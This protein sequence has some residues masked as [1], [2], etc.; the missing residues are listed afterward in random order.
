MSEKIMIE[1]TI[2]ALEGQRSLLGNGV[3]DVTTAVLREKLATHI[4]ATSQPTQRKL[5]TILFATI[6]GLNQTGPNSNENLN[7]VLMSA[8]WEQLT[9]TITQQGGTITAQTSTQL[10][11]VFG[12]PTSREDD[13]ERAVSTAL[14]LKETFQNFLL[15]LQGYARSSH[16]ELEQLHLMIGLNTG[17]VF[18]GEV[19][20]RGEYTVLGDAVNVASRL[21]QLAP[22]DTVLISH[23]THALLRDEF[24]VE[25]LGPIAVRGKQEPVRVYEVR[26]VRKRPLTFNFGVSGVV[27]RLVG[28]EE[29]FE[30]L[31]ESLTKTLQTRTGE[32][33]MVVGQAGLGKSRLVYEF[34][35]WA[36]G[37]P[38]KISIIN[39]RT[40]QQIS[41]SASP[42]A[43][44]RDI[45][46]T[47]ANLQ[48]NDS[49]TLAVEKLQQGFA[50]SVALPES[51]IHSQALAIANLLGYKIEGVSAKE[52]SLE[53]ASAQ[54]LRYVNE[55]LAELASRGPVIFVLEDLHWADSSSLQ[56]IPQMAQLC[57]QKPLLLV[58]TSRPELWERWP[59]YSEALSHVPHGFV[60]L[61]RLPEKALDALVR[62]L[63][64][65]L[66][67]IP[68]ELTQTIVKRSEG[69]PFFLQ[70]F[71]RMLIEDGV[72]VANEAQWQFEADQFTDLRVP[73]TLMGVVQSRLEHLSPIELATLQRAS[74]IGR[75][76]WET[77]VL[78]MNQTSSEPFSKADTLAALH[79]LG[80]REMIYPWGSAYFGGGRGY[81]FQH[82]ILRDVTYESVLLRQ[83]PVY[84]RQVAQWLEHHGQEQLAELARPI[85]KHYE[86][87]NEVNKAV[88]WYTKAGQYAEQNHH[89][90]TALEA[91]QQALYLL[92]DRTDWSNPQN[93]LQERVG[94]LLMRQGRWVEAAETFHTLQFVAQ[95][96]GDL[97]LQAK[98]LNGLTAVYEQ[99]GAYQAMLETATEAE[100]AAWLVDIETEWV[101]ALCGQIKAHAAL[102]NV[103][104][105]LSMGQ[106]A[107]TAQILQEDDTLAATYWGLLAQI[108]LSNGRLEQA[109]SY[110]Q[111]LYRLNPDSAVGKAAVQVQVARYRLGQG[112][113]TD[114]QAL[115]NKACQTYRTSDE[116]LLLIAT[117]RELGEVYRFS[118]QPETALS[119]YQE[120]VHIA[121]SIGEQAERILSQLRLTAVYLENDNYAAAEA[122]LQPVLTF[123][124]DNAKTG[125]WHES[126][127]VYNLSA[128]IY[129]NQKKLA[130][131]WL[132]VNRSHTLAQNLGQTVILAVAWRLR[133]LILAHFPPHDL[134]VEINGTLYTITA[135]FQESAQLLRHQPYFHYR[136][137]LSQTLWH[138]ANHERGQGET[139]VSNQL[140]EEAKNLA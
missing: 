64:Q 49:P 62:D 112:Q 52:I 28:R 73:P 101:K 85:A 129:L 53:T 132:A 71:V 18:L 113:L 104:Q 47:Y 22:P 37:L 99:Q 131:A 121:E 29:E 118:R 116:H 82:A 91:Y 19:G 50:Q 126:A 65:K 95:Q 128:Q 114:A 134:P 138:W 56:M 63:L 15:E 100:R 40:P 41:Q 139:A 105:A 51:Q 77:A 135:C 76:F 36:R 43:L 78:H 127:E 61:N 140:I 14:S 58:A 93:P 136:Y 84:H 55:L 12:M 10:M 6:A 30:I 54:A 34:E 33:M 81:I 110:L 75:L 7:V 106:K 25:S 124:E 98:S 87:A 17:P 42:F 83:R 3:V 39:G 1:K 123:A 4:P 133:G 137:Q 92:A 20:G 119:L 9:R 46:K 103:A 122:T 88:E 13:P 8:L 108:C 2:V 21:A 94:E 79:N 27:T 125:T 35:Q 109:E 59:G 89:P 68:A 90:Q 130:E 102:Q 120:A 111:K 32:L 31:Q 80:K 74:V 11:A 86:Y 24:V 107:A 69:N 38:E 70:E 5:A 96:Q 57:W 44:L 16:P 117:L 48:E 60:E 97:A 66:P 23:D 115:L 72:I 26:S 45:L 67:H